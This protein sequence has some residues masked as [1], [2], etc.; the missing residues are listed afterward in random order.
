MR[1][2]CVTRTRQ[3]SGERIATVCQYCSDRT[4]GE[5]WAEAN[6]FAVSHGTCSTCL[7]IHFPG[8]PQ[9]HID[10]LKKQEGIYI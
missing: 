9:I 4:Q 5:A 10:N 1:P 2:K 7:P 6:V 8:I 3:E